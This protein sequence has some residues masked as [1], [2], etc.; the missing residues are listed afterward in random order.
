MLTEDSIDG[1]KLPT[2]SPQT[3][4]PTAADELES[5]ILFFFFFFFTRPSMGEHVRG[6]VETGQFFAVKTRKG[7]H[8]HNRMGIYL[9][10][11]ILNLWLPVREL[12]WL[13]LSVAT[14]CGN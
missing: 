4:W 10:Q 7:N 11:T 3:S 6:S 14:S 13:V 2:G 5:V 8:L 9:Y 12:R 1:D